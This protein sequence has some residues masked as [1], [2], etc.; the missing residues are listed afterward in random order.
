LSVGFG[1]LCNCLTSHDGFLFLQESLYFMMDPDQL[2]L[3]CCVFIFF[4]FLIS[5]LHLD[6]IKLDI[7]LNDLYC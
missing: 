6:L 1:A 3:L 4:S 7:A 2:L 5:I